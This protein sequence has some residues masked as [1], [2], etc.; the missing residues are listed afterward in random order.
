MPTIN[1]ISGI[2][3]NFTGQNKV[4][5]KSKFVPNEALHDAFHCAHADVIWTSDW[6]YAY[7]RSFA[8][9][10]EHLLNDGKD[11]L[12]KVTRSKTASSLTI[13]GERVNFHRE[14]PSKPGV[15]DGGR[16]INNIVDYFS[17]KGI[18]DTSKLAPNELKAV[19]PEIDTLNAELNADD[20]T[21]N[22]Q[23]LYNLE[24]NLCNINATL[25]ELT[26]K[27]LEKLEA[28]IFRK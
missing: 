2:E 7:A 15:V 16:V 20:V 27:L 12:I 18:V 4:S 17:K 3:N 25:H 23:I 5:F 28:T 6:R 13:N 1:K 21:K 8:K 9:I 10:I 26:D 14:S 22:P 19:K 24:N 11:D